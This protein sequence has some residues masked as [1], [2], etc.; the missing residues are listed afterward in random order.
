MFV[1]NTVRLC[2]VLSKTTYCHL[3]LYRYTQCRMRIQTELSI[4]K[5]TEQVPTNKYLVLCEV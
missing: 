2:N 1:E 5:K 4:P 3:Q